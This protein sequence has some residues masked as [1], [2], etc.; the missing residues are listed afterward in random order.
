M[1]LAR[2]HPHLGHA[3]CDGDGQRARLRNRIVEGEQRIGEAGGAGLVPRRLAYSR[4]P[5]S[6]LTFG[7]SHACVTF[8]AYDGA[9]LVAA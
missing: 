3:L 8:C 1:L 6:C 5:A 7:G 9:P 4:R 2:A